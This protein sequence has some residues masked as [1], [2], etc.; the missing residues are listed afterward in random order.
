MDTKTYIFIYFY[1]QYLV[2]FTIV[3]RNSG[4]RPFWWFRQG[5]LV[6]L[7]VAIGS[8]S[9]SLEG[10]GPSGIRSGLD[11]GCQAGDVP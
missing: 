5:A 2:L 6:A 4:N 3:L 1:E 9:V 10:S 8:P 11:A 7:L